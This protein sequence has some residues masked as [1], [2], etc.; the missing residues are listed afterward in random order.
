MRNLIIIVIVVALI[1]GIIFWRFGDAIMNSVNKPNPENEQV[2]LT[3]WGLF[4]EE[5]VYRTVIATYE[6]DHPNVKIVYSKESTLNY[7]PRLQTQLR[8]GQGPD[9]F[10]IHSSWV[11][12]FAGDLAAAPETIFPTNSFVTAYYPIV[13]DNL[14]VANRVYGI[15]MEVDGLGMYY[16]EDILRFAGVDVP[17]TWQQFLDAA[18]KLTVKNDKGQIQ[19]AGASL[20]TAS[21]VDDWPEILGLLFLQQPSTSLASPGS[22]GGVDVIRFYTSFIIDPQN[23]TWDVTL[24]NSTQMFIDGKLAFYFADSKK[25]AE[26]QSANPNL[27]FKVAPVPQ[28]PGGETNWGGFWDYSVSTKQTYTEAWKFLQYLSTPQAMQVL[29]QQKTQN[30]LVGDAFPRRDMA[31]LLV[32]DPIL[33]AYV[34]EAPTMKGWFLNSKIKDAGINDEVISLYG[35]AVNDVLSGS[36]PEQALQGMDV[37]IKVIIDKYTK[38]PTPTIKK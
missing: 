18:R 12:M 28:L 27:K 21:N 1:A 7:R 6:Q 24:P 29:Y 2:I 13:K 10:M 5:Q 17:K 25:A 16:N 36:S 23:K 15:P 37:K 35:K 4:D 34:S 20:G 26:I 33:G 30:Q 38:A 9:I 14:V 31:D 3:W 19:T 11:P 32:N 8:A 22:K